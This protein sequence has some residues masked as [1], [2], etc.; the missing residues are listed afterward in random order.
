MESIMPVVTRDCPAARDRARVGQFLWRGGRCCLALL[1]LT[2]T[3]HAL[4]DTVT[5]LRPYTARY[6]TSV[7]GMD[8]T[9]KR[10]LRQRESQWTLT[11]SGSVLFFSLNEDA[12]FHIDQGRIIANAFLYRLKGPVNR[13]REVQ[14]D[15]A[16]QM[17]RSLR[18]DEWSEH[19]WS[20]EVLDRL[21]AQE[22]LRVD[23]MTATEVPERLTSTI[24]DGHRI[25]TR[26]F[27]FIE[28]VTITTPAGEFQTLRYDQIHD[29]PE[30]Q[31]T[32][33]FA[34]NADYLLVRSEHIEDNSTITVSLKSLRWDDLTVETED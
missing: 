13:R 27:Q 34:V 14:F 6:D 9:L 10:Q 16:E 19:P 21:S 15:P 26:E 20:P 11:N 2:L 24:I 1:L 33:W 22:Q 3:P 29:N 17:I 25:K 30:R 28:A 8:I 5:A 23:L 4:G 32:L 18:K 31:S 12:Q 7:M